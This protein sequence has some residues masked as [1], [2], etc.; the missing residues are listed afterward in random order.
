MQE[1]AAGKF[2]LSK[3]STRVCLEHAKIFQ[4]LYFSW[5]IELI[6][7]KF[8]HDSYEIPVFQ[9]DPENI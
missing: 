3:Y 7:V 2:F 1:Q 5:E 6:P 8:L 9:T 4:F